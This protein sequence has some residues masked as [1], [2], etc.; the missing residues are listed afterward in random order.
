MRV[1]PACYDGRALETERK[2][3]PMRENILIVDVETCGPFGASK[4]YDLGCAIVQR[5][6]G[7]RLAARSFVVPEVYYGKSHEMASAFYANKLPQYARGIESGAWDVYPFHVIRT[8][9]HNLMAEYNVRRVF[10]YNMKF[11]RDAL[12]Y[13]TA[14][15]SRGECAEF[16]PEGTI[17]CDIWTA[18]CTTIMRQKGYRKFCEAHGFVSAAGNIRTTAEVCY[19]YITNNATFEEQHTGLADVEIETEILTHAIRQ[20]KKMDENIRHNTW[21]IPQGV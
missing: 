7:R 9:V 13:T 15:I 14:G 8:M 11:D 21:K 17:F 20:H 10:A 5:T 4:V 2:T 19:S 6:T 12:N 3:N 18:A 16:F 1:S